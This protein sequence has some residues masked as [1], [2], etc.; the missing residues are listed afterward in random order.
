M[1][2]GTYTQGMK[3]IGRI[4]QGRHVQKRIGDGT[5]QL[6]LVSNQHQVTI[7]SARIVPIIFQVGHPFPES[8]CM[9]AK[10][11]FEHLRYGLKSVFRRCTC[12]SA[13]VPV[14]GTSFPEKWVFLVTDSPVLLLTFFSAA[15][16][17]V[18][19]GTCAC[20]VAGCGI[21]GLRRCC[22]LV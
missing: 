7:C 3:H 5:Q 21:A 13:Q 9:A 11:A 15:W 4:A 18:S 16:R 6:L 1:D 20:G 17:G 12:R 19:L 14:G 2:S 8:C 22:T 10:E